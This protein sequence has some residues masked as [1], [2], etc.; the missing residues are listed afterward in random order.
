ME[1]NY[2][3]PEMVTISLEKYNNLLAN[4]IDYK[5]L[6][7]EL[8]E[9]EEEIKWL[10]RHIFNKTF[11]GMSEVYDSLLVE[12]YEIGFTRL[13]IFTFSKELKARNKE[14]LENGSK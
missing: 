8:K 9:S 14:E 10:K 3:L 5:V 2:G 4:S 11:D 12:L 6:E 7:K 13:E 1:E